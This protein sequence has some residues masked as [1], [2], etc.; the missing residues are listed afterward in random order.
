M[1]AFP[2]FSALQGNRTRL[3]GAYQ[4]CVR[5]SAA[6][7][8]PFCAVMAVVAP[9]LILVFLGPKWA[10]AVTPFR[11][12]LAVG[13]MR[14]LYGFAALVLRAVGRPQIELL[15]QSFF[16]AGIAM[17]VA[18]GARGG[19]N[20]VAAGVAGFV[21]L[22]GGPLFITV[23]ARVSGVGLIEV[24]RC[25]GGPAAAA[26]VAGVVAFAAGRVAAGAWPEAPGFVLL[27][28]GA[29]AGL[30]AYGVALRAIAGDLFGEAR[31]RLVEALRR[32][33]APAVVCGV[34]AGLGPAVPNTESQS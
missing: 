12:L 31:S 29:G 10:A 1:V 13:A 17:S 34:S 6:L 25:A 8:L 23:A 30:L 19:I 27:A 2:A 18:V 15:I 7:A 32:E 5:W 20:G 21:C 16:C 14:S 3:A 24:L 11:L 26:G 4:R 28:S 33:R 22:V 9:Q